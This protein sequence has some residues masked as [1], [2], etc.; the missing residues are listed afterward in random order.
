M[1]CSFV[2]VG[3]INLAFVKLGSEVWLFFPAG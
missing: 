3:I 1:V 2:G